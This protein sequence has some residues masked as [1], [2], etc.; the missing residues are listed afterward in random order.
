MTLFKHEPLDGMHDSVSYLDASGYE[1]EEYALSVI[2]E[3]KDHINDRLERGKVSKCF[4][5]ANHPDFDARSDGE[6]I[7]TIWVE[8]H[9]A[10]GTTL[11]IETTGFRRVSDT[12]HV[13]MRRF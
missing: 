5:E 10:D 7:V 6:H 3:V 9:N 1:T 2:R 4:I 8:S 13:D 11:P 12:I